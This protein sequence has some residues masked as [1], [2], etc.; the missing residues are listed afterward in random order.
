MSTYGKLEKVC[1][2]CIYWKGKRGVEV[3]FVQAQSSDAECG[4]KDGFTGLIT[5]EGASCLSWK[6]FN[7]ENK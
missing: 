3:N 1:A 6:G 7:K 5:I 4:N 2:T